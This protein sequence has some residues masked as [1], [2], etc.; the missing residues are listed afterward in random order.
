M[1][2][3]ASREFFVYPLTR[4]RGILIFCVLVLHVTGGFKQLDPPGIPGIV[5]AILHG[6][7][8]AG[9]PLFVLVSGF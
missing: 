7:G 3:A 4:L 5:L 9:L 2:T 6:L 1:Q 8:R